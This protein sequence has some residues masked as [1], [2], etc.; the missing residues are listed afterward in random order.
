MS[1]F[2]KHV[3]KIYNS[4][5]CC[6]CGLCSDFCP[7]NAISYEADK[8]G[9]YRPMIDHSLCVDCK[10]CEDNCPGANDLKNYSASA[11]SYC[12]G[13]S[14][15]MEMHLNASSGGITT[16]LLCYLIREKKVDYVTCVTNRTD[17]NPPQQILTN[18][19]R[20]IRTNRTSKY[21]PV[22]WEGIVG[23][24]D[25]CNG[26]VAVVAMPCQINALKRYYSKKRKCNVKYFISLMCNHTPSLNAADYLAEAISGESGLLSIVNRGGGF[27]GYMFVDVYDK[28][29]DKG[30][31]PKNREGKRYRFPY[32]KT[33]AAGYGLY[34]K[35][36]RCQLCNDP[37][38]KNADIVMADSYFLQ[39]SDKEGTTFC[40]VRN[41][42]IESVL[43]EMKAND[44]ITLE[45]GPSIEL[46]KKYYRVLYQ[47][48]EEF[49]KKNKMLMMLG[50]PSVKTDVTD[51]SSVRCSFRE[52][53][54]FQKQIFMSQLGR[55]HWLWK[56]LI[57]KHKVKEL[58][59]QAFTYSSEC[60]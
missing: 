23:Q 42:E 31:L 50:K 1:G 33:W 32:R 16:E 54:R 44:I 34:F 3:E 27:P 8:L 48:E 15:D 39:D 21:C 5:L 11:E 9:F 12:Y 13:Y 35:N 43:N 28:N 58:T 37:F 41:K 51:Y 53:L 40:I 52:A 59:E 10:V 47:R 22:R 49:A 14:N 2:S 29:E 45:Q 25:R 26:T 57:W 60:L 46:Q 24:I 30:S 18:D 4:G 56:Y 36:Q 17:D 19:I 38:S 20:E 7:K 55:Y 6:S